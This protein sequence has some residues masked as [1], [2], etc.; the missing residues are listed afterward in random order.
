MQRQRFQTE[1]LPLKDKLFRLA[2]RITLNRE[3]AQDVVQETM[4]RVWDARERWDTIESMEA[5]CLT[6]CR[7]QALD[8]VRKAGRK[9]LSL[10]EEEIQPA[11]IETSPHE[12]MERGEGMKLIRQAMD[13][14]PETQRSI[15]E[16][17]DIEG[18]RYDE[19]ALLL[20]LS[21]TQVKV[22]LHRA[23]KK[24]K[25]IIEQIEHYGL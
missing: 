9:E 24:I 8:F 3:D 18:K 22:Y 1:V 21:E 5:F 19:I 16:L 12:Q 4:L 23:R 7:N 25:T 2:L 6:I 20:S 17:R 11:M 13:S 14:L 15:M 10:E